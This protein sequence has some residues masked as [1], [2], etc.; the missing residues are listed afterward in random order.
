MRKCGQRTNSSALRAVYWWL[1]HDYLPN[2]SVSLESLPLPS[3]SYWMK[4]SFLLLDCL[5]WSNPKDSGTF[6]VSPPRA[7]PQRG[8]LLKDNSGFWLP[9]AHFLWPYSFSMLCFSIKA[10]G[11]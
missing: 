1:S 8:R 3:P 5:A 10:V 9:V 11:F 2:V 4:F 7:K 6:R